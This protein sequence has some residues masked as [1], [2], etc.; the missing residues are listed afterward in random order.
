MSQF[1]NEHF[2]LESLQAQKLYHDFAKEMPIIDYHN[3]L[4]PKMIADNY[5]FSTITEAWLYGDHYKWRAMRTNGIAEKYCTGD[6]SDW[7]KFEKWAI[8]VPYTVQNPLFHWTHLELQRYFGISEFLNKSSAKKIYEQCN[9]QLK[10]DSTRVQQLLQKMNVQ[11][12]GTTDD[13]LDDLQYHQAIKQSDFQIK[14]LPSFRPDKAIA[15]NNVADFTIYLKKLEQVAGIKI[16]DFDSYTAALKSRHDYFSANGCTVSDHGVEKLY[17]ESYTHS[18]LAA[19]FKLVQKGEQPDNVA[20]AKFKSAMLTL[21]A[22]W[23]FEKNWVQQYHMGPI[24]N[25]NSR[26]FKQLG[27]DTGWDSIGNAVDLQSVSSFLD[28][29]DARGK[30][31]KTILYSINPNDNDALATMVGNFNDGSFPG[32]VQLGAAWWFND[33]MDGMIN[34]LKSVGNMGLLSRFVGMLT[35]S[36]SFLSFPRH[37]YFRRILC[38][39]LGEEMKK[40]RLP[41]DEKW[42]GSIVQNICYNNAKHYFDL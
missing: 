17:A 11:Y 25:N 41:N 42:I 1:I 16:D 30:L 2:L 21:L 36:R 35:D 19:I 5:S 20:I 27:A 4:S 13:P 28:R 15:I 9:E 23:G 29:L 12:V 39:F 14:V 3:H 26:M 37:E 24:R 32:K 31:A 18:E 40:G 6:A 7:D 8:T 22:E 33:Q 38:N 10:N 34:H